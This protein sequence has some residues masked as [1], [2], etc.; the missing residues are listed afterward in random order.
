MSHE[1]L[2]VL[3]PYSVQYIDWHTH[4]VVSVYISDDKCCDLSHYWVSYIFKVLYG[5]RSVKTS[6]ITHDSRFDVSL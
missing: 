1:S 4:C 6:L 5:T 2:K 3:C